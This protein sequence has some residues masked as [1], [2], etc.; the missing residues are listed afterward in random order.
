L[1]YPRRES[2]FGRWWGKLE[3]TRRRFLGATALFFLS[4]R[5]AL[6]VEE[7][8]EAN[9]AVVRAVC[10]RLVPKYRDHPGAAALGI[11][12]RVID[13]FRRSDRRSRALDFAI[14]E[15]RQAKFTQQDAGAQDAIL[16]RYMD[17]DN[18]SRAAKILVVL[19]NA[20]VVFY[21]SSAESWAPIRYRTPQPNGFP[22]YAKCPEKAGSDVPDA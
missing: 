7:D 12:P 8:R 3:T 20:T 14:A 16:A 1:S 11:E 15:L 18:D 19:R 22:D 4:P 5:I 9:D 21:F 2:A 13:W 17:P 10:N 6:A